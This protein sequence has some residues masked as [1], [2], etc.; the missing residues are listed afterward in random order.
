MKARFFLACCAGLLLWA[1]FAPLELWIAPVLGLAMLF[2]I[3]AEQG[4]KNRSG[5]AFVAALTYFL[6]L[7]HWSSTYVGAL[8]WL[9]LAVG[10]SLIFTIIAAVPMPKNVAGV[11][12]FAS[13]FTI[14]ELM[15]M[16]LPFG[17]FG[18]GRIGFTQIESLAFY[19]PIFGV[20]GITFAVAFCAGFAVLRKPNILLFLTL[21]LISFWFTADKTSSS[22][23]L[24]IIAV[25]G[26][27]TNLG[28]DFNSRAL[29]VLNRHIDA[30]PRGGRADLIIWPENSVDI[31]PRYNFKAREA[32][33]SL[34]QDVGTPLLTGTVERGDKGPKN[35]SLLYK[36][37]GTLMARY[38]KQDLAPF[39]EYIP[40]RFIAER[41]SPLATR[42]RDFMPGGNWVPM[43][44]NGWKFQSFICFEILDDDHIKSGAKGMDFVIAQ[45]NNATFGDSSQAAQQLQISR[46]R[47]AELGKQMAVVSTTGYTAH[48]GSDGAVIA[49]LKQFK[50]G[51]LEM[52]MDKA[53]LD[54]FASRINTLHWALGLLILLTLSVVRISR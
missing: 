31:D 53:K 21:F 16:K 17:G 5:L 24:K 50:P 49:K 42:V 11:M 54:S 43:Q 3:L 35:S 26:G 12:R 48:L 8:P 18:W 36:P 22:A 39:G 7:L 4:F 40:F 6:P 25:Q 1:G 23:G 28:L 14:V 13:L 15:R 34:L 10:E 51:Y 20:T 44:I 38:V 52:N 30:T 2:F 29:E 46:A 19:Y 33:D 37:D 27:V 47:A 45:T 9:I 32:L 41:V